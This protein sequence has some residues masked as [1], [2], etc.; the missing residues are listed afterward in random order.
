M[1]KER[2]DIVA[3]KV[4]VVEVPL[5]KSVAARLLVIALL[6][7]ADPAALLPPQATLCDDLE[8]M[9]RAVCTL[10]ERP[11][12]AV[13]NLKDSGTAK[14][15]LTAVCASTPGLTAELQMSER[16]AERPIGELLK[17]LTIYTSARFSQPDK[18]T[19]KIIGGRFAG[20]DLA[21]NIDLSH[22]SQTCTALMLVAPRGSSPI[23]L[24][25]SPRPASLSY[26]QMT[27]E[28]MRRCG[29]EV[30]FDPPFTNLRVLPGKYCHPE[31][32]M[33]EA[34]WSAATFFYEY[35]L[36]SGREIEI[37]GLCAPQTS[38]QG[39]ANATAGIFNT[40]GVETQVISTGVRLIPVAESQCRKLDVELRS[41][42]DLVPALAV[43][44]AMKGIPFLLRGL[45]HLRYK[46]SDRLEILR[47]ALK[48][49]GVEVR[50]GIDSLEY[51]GHS[52]AVAP[53]EPVA[54]AADHRIA[55]AI[56]QSAVL[57]PGLRIDNM[58]CVNKSFPGFWT[59]MERLGVRM[60]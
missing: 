26:V 1:T 51:D 8:V 53:T 49:F 6:G 5:S 46:E 40:L 18:Q 47:R 42:P 11:E 44:C 37:K 41:T 35:A 25:L 10:K 2:N 56:A 55:M 48:S 45:S 31:V 19:L 36:L 57:F 4:P 20:L 43:A 15:L 14:R 39:D 29:V 50:V 16:L 30:M 60:L 3:N 21:M 34:D 32:S 52:V 38:V 12:R 17:L 28:L 23:Q 13:L 9:L 27:A 33:L 22:S 24:H 59:Q 7:G 54:V 58:E